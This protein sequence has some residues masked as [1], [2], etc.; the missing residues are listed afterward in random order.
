MDGQLGSYLK[1]AAPGSVSPKTA[2][3]ILIIGHVHDDRLLGDAPT[4]DRF[5]GRVIL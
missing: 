2:Q 3:V 1:G 5:F 4:N